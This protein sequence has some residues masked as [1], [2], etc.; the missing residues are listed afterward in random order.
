VSS[1]VIEVSIGGLPIGATDGDER[2]AALLNRC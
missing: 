2:Y 1:V